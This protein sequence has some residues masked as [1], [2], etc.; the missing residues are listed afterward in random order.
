MYER[1]EKI[2]LSCIFIL[3]SEVALMKDSSEDQQH[4]HTEPE[5][6]DLH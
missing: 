3:I 1:M 5:Q 4:V 2:G 6:H